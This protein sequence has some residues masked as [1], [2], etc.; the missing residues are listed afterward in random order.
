ML[1]GNST[2]P[3]LAAA[4][5]AWALLAPAAA[6]AA[7]TCHIS[8]VE[9]PVTMVGL[10]PTVTARINDIDARFLVDSGAFFSMITPAGA[11]QLGLRLRRAPDKL[12]VEGIGGSMDV[13]MTRVERFVLKNTVFPDVEFIVGGSEYGA[14]ALGLI[15]QNFLGSADVEYDLANGSVRI[16]H[17]DGDC[18]HAALAYWARSEPVVELDLHRRTRYVSG[19][20]STATVNGAE[21]EVQ[22]DTGAAMSVMSMHAARKAG[23]VPGGPGVVPGGSLHGIGRDEIPTWIAP[24]KE[25]TL[26]GEQIRNTHLRF[27]DIDLPNTD[28]LLGADF[29]LSHHVYVANSQDKLYFTYNGG[30]AFNLSVSPDRPHVPLGSEAAATPPEALPAPSD[31]YAYARRGAAFVAR[32][33][34][35]RALSDLTHACEL[36]PNVGKYFLE[37]GQVRARLRQ[38]LLAM[39]DFN[40]AVRL[41]PDD[42]DARIARARLQIAGHDDDAARADL[43][44]ADRLSAPQADIRRQIGALYVRLDQPAAALR[45]YDQWLAA[46]AEDVERG[47][48]LGNRCRARALIGTELDKALDDCTEALDAKPDSVPVLDSRGLVHLRRGEFDKA[49]ADYD[50][51]LRVNPKV[52][53]SLY[54]RGLVRLH[55]GETDAG[56]AD[57]AAAKA[58]VPSIESDARHYGIQP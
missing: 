5:V 17:A 43:D 19:T 52:P 16:N 8:S 2:A 14:D 44:V 11:Q 57:I 32:G 40:E 15:G 29:F 12:H 41:G 9:L 26:G 31:A 25:F 49:L 38:Q 28:M 30:P 46:H 6:A 7:P 36:D 33:D 23:I 18:R 24:V 50:A 45:Q 42:V 4:I 53:W 56:N 37:R 20:Q 54:G 51:A 35:E 39:S 34:L 55:Q 3:V 22:F 13:H 21:I 10:R 27:G 1:P 48:V 47:A 58:L